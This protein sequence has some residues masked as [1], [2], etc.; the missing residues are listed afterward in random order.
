MLKLENIS[1][2]Y[3]RKK[4]VSDF[5]LKVEE[6]DFLVILGPSGSGKTTLL[7]LIAGLE[8]PDAG[9]I[10]IDNK[11][12]SSG[13]NIVSPNK[14]ELGMV[15]QDLAL[16]PHMTLKENIVFGFKAKKIS[17]EEINNKVD[18]VLK[19]VHL[20]EHYKSYPGELS[21]G[22]RQ[23]LALARSLVLE[24][25]VLLLDEPLS[26]LDPLLKD[27]MIDLIKEIYEKFK[28]TIVYVT[29]EQTEAKLL[30]TKVAIMDK[31]VLKQTGTYE[32]LKNNPQDEFV[33]RFIKE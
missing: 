21:G 23:R 32:E 29:H 27:K 7:R 3:K 24:P 1:K 17:K 13:R 26:S 31:G 10:F 11:L 16:W 33:K 14:R 12:V 9:E 20:D 28:I 8:T 25:K 18:K 15:F 6:G 30:G 2:S 22:E 19:L 4:V 5:S